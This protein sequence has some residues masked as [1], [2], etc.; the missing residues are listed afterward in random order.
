MKKNKFAF[1]LVAILATSMLTSCNNGK[2]STVTETQP[3]KNASGTTDQ[4][5]EQPP[6]EV[7]PFE[8][9]PMEISITTLDRSQVSASEGSYEQ[10][11]WVDWINE[12]SPVKVNIVPVTRTEA[13]SKINALFAAGSAPDLVWEF[14]K[15]FMDNLY[16]QGVLQPVGDY[17]DQYS[18]EYKQYLEVHPE[19]MPYLMQNDGLQY[20][21]TS[22]RNIES[23]PNHAMWI[24]QDWLNEFGMTMPQTLD[25]I[26]EFMTRVRDE[27]PDG[28]GVDDTFGLGFNYNR[29]DITRALFGAPFKDF[30]IEDG[31]YV[32]WTA[33]DG[34]EDYL[35]FLAMCFKEGFMDPE[36]IT[37]DQ[38]ARQRQLLITGKTGIY[39]GGWN[40]ENEWRELNQNI[41]E[42][43]WV[44]LEPFETQHGKNGLFQEPPANKMI[45]MNKDAK[46]PKAV[47]AYLDWMIT[48]GWYPLLYGEEGVHYTLVSGIPQTI[49][50]DKNNEE[51][52]YASEYAIVDQNQF[53]DDWFPIRAA[54]DELSQAYVPFKILGNETALKNPYNRQVPFV[55]TSDTIIKFEQDIKAQVESIETNIITGVVSV[56]EGVKQIREFKSANGWD[57][58]NVEKDQWYQDNKD[59]F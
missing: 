3:T 52:R 16:A 22:A 6:A 44:P 27:D 39:M 30:I 19:L 49:D 7:D 43:E 47:M 50:I 25:E 24:R 36:H 1:M 32:D 23:I 15:G 45:C 20:G 9:L 31:H 21:M 17:I 14:G 18:V 35:G 42:A 37:D 8:G 51:I 10:N 53:T 48:D 41:P 2:E 56:K 4:S 55:P 33:T 29:N 38:Y 12:N 13:T 57:E 34:Y 54:Q 11:R 58:I 5:G 26:I 28:N 46:N 40:M 59:T